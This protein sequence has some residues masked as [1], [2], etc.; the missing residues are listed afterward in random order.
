MHFKW[1]LNQLSKF[2][3]LI[4]KLIINLII[5]IVVIGLVLSTKDVKT[6]EDTLTDVKVEVG[7]FV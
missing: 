4:K 6:S 5:F 1:C 2:K 7:E 3:K